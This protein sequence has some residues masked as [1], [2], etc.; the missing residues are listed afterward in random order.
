MDTALLPA[1]PFALR[2]HVS[3]R[4]VDSCL[5]RNDGTSLPHST[6]CSNRA[7]TIS[8]ATELKPARP[9]VK[10]ASSACERGTAV[11]AAAYGK[12]A[13]ASLAGPQLA[14]Q[15]TWPQL[16]SAARLASAGLSGTLGLS[17]PGLSAGL[18]STD[19]HTCRDDNICESFRRLDKLIMHWT[20]GGHILIDDRINRTTA[21]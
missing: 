20:D 12:R 18:P 4:G 9:K 17:W 5:F 7:I 15:L 1:A 13:R 11:L 8:S 21:R 3:R 19:T 10:H 2:C 16:A 6:N 14:S